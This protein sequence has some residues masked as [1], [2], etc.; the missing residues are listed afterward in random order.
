M[1][2]LFP[3]L[4]A[5]LQA[6][7]SIIDKMT[8]SIKRVTYRTYN[9]ISFPLIFIFTLIIFFLIRPDFS[10]SLF[11]T[12]LVIFLLISTIIS[13][14]TNLLYYRAL[15]KDLLSEM[16]TFSLLSHIPLIAAASLFFLD[17]R[18]Y[19]VISLAIISALSLV[20]SHY[21][22]HHFR[23][24]KKTFPFF[25]WIIFLAPFGGIINKIILETLNPISMQLIR[26]FL[27]LLVFIPLFYKDIKRAPKKAYLFLA[28]TNILTTIA[29]ILYF[30][31][32]QRFGIVYTVLLFSLEPILV[33]LASLVLLKEKLNYKKLISFIIILITIT[34]SQIIK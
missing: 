18:N 9:G 10:L 32:Y 20:W 25:L 2:F 30:F 28:I 17:E 26:D 5:V 11:N 1:N 12:K 33:Y 24:S 23:I 15:K 19:F 21:E 16:Q 6:S 31:S 14:I 27:I 3:V 13:L 22:R 8:L 4:A 29:W 34:L 7:S